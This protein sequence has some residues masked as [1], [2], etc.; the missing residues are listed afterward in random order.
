MEGS[1]DKLD[2]ENSA[3]GDGEMDGADTRQTDHRPAAK[4]ETNLDSNN[5]EDGELTP[6]KIVS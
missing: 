1:G 4:S 3:P 5:K 6:R 2:G